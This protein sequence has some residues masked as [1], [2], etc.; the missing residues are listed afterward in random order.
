MAS[1]AVRSFLDS[2]LKRGKELTIEDDFVIIVGKG[3]RSAEDPILLPTLQEL[4]KL[5][6]GVT[7]EVEP[8]N[9]GRLIIK[10]EAL[11]AL[12]AGRRW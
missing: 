12:I 4:L 8:E 10:A 9:K 3:L 6:Y 5:E 7:A 1:S 11:R 2:L